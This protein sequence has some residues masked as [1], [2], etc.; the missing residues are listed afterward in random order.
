M[1]SSAISIGTGSC[2]KDHPTTV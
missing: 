2:C 1:N